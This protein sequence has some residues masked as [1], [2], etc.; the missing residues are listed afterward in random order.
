MSIRQVGA[1]GIIW[2]SPLAVNND[3]PNHG[4]YPCKSSVPGFEMRV[5]FCGRHLLI[6][7]MKTRS[8]KALRGC[9]ECVKVWVT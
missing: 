7:V 5:I 8:E 3:S 6:S 4:Q 9:K 1:D 2:H